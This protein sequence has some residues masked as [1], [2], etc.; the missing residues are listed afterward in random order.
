MNLLK[1]FFGLGCWRGASHGSCS[2]D[3]VLVLP[4]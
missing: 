3:A 1:R 2:P 4:A